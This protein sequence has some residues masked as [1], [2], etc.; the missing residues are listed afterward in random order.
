LENEAS[1]GHAVGGNRSGLSQSPSMQQPGDEAS[2]RYGPGY[3][4]VA[5]GRSGLP[6]YSS[7]RPNCEPDD[8]ILM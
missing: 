7:I 3:P 5:S 6:V 1:E 8:E 4:H 2:K